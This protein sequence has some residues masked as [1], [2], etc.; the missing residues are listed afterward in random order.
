MINKTRKI[1]EKKKN[2]FSKNMKITNLIVPMVALST[3]NNPSYQVQAVQVEM[4]MPTNSVGPLG[5]GCEDLL[6]AANECWKDW[7]IV[8]ATACYSTA[9]ALYLACKAV[10]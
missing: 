6:A 4:E 9:F 5:L 1:Q 7:N 8:R 3:I 10:V 2:K